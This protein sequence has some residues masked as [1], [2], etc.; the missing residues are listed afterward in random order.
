M[1]DQLKPGGRL[2]L[3]VGASYGEQVLEVVDKNLDGSISREKLMG[4]VYVPLTD[5]AKQRKL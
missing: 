5:A 3:P 4:V 2:V 1:V